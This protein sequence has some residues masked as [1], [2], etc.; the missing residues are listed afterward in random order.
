MPRSL[1]RSNAAAFALTAFAALVA[2]RR[3]AAEP[4]PDLR[5]LE[6][7]LRGRD[8]EELAGA[9]ADATRAGAGARPLR[10]QIEALAA[11][12][13]PPLLALAA[14]EA[15]GAIGAR[16]SV[17][18]VRRYLGHR[19]AELRLGAVAALAKAGGPAAVAALRSAL[20]DSEARVRGGA[21][22]AL[23][24]LGA[25]ETTGDLYRALDRGLPEAAPA[26][27]RLC[28]A[29]ACDGLEGRLFSLPFALIAP[30]CDTLL[31]RP[32]SEVPDGQK[33]ALLR[34]LHELPPGEVHRFVVAW[35]ARWAGSPVVAEALGRAV[36]A[37]AP[38]R[39]D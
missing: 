24:D 12:G 27:G 10:P 34:R 32:A 9:L 39:R 28:S 33:V 38:A 8:P 19:L 11:R 2:P 6:A 4:P 7:K 29:S 21:A 30:G 13:L 3:A 31:F 18:I 23:A 17:P 22:S 15:L 36:E 16:E 37:T 25:V 20:D 14:L 1:L 35:R 5:A 26:I